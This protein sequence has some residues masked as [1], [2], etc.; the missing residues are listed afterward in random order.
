[1]SGGPKEDGETTAMKFDVDVELSSL[2][3]KKVLPETVA[4]KLGEKL[5]EKNVQITKDQLYLLVEKIRSLLQSATNNHIDVITEDTEHHDTQ[6]TSETEPNMQ[7]I[8]EKIEEMQQQIRT[9]LDDKISYTCEKDTSS[10]IDTEQNERKSTIVT[11]DD[12][13]LP[14]QSEN[15]IPSIS[16]DPL[17]FLPSDPKSII[18]LMNWL[19]YLI[20]RCGHE[21]L[22]NILDYY[23]DVEWISDEV[24]IS[25]L[26][27]SQG[28]T[29]DIKPANKQSD[30]Q[31]VLLPS[32][33]H[34]QSF[35][36]IQKLKGKEFDKHFI[37]RISGELTRLIKKVDTYQKP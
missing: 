23:V 16:T 32:K 4:E 21:N 12:I 27:Y 1:M 17:L 29:S 33:D 26:D 37:E 30:K 2:V 14:T 24:K 6:Y 15:S 20:D 35:L 25:L 22:S 10:V 13:T 31:I 8:Q 7:S 19:Q 3:A 36:F 5:K 9:L 28:I 18:V 11:T 34:I